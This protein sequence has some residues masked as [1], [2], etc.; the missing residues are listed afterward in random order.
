MTVHDRSGPEETGVEPLLLDAPPAVEAR[1]S[2]A[3]LAA[4]FC[5]TGALLAAPFRLTGSL[6]LVLALLGC[7]ASV[8]G[9]VATRH[10]LVAGRALAPAGLLFSLVAL[11]LLAPRF[12]EL[13]TAFGDLFAPT[14]VDLLEQLNTLFQLR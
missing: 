12:A 5:G 10:P 2:A 6:A 4:T 8:A 1:T 9:L 14:L 11:V 13:D 7:V 3:A